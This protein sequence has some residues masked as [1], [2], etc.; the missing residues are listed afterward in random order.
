MDL[1]LSG[2]VTRLYRLLWSKN[3][4]QE[5]NFEAFTA[6]IFSQN[7]LY[8]RHCQSQGCHH[9]STAPVFKIR[10]FGTI[11]VNY[12]PPQ[13]ILILMESLANKTRKQSWFQICSVFA[14]YLTS[15][16][17]WYIVNPHRSWMMSL[18]LYFLR[19]ILTR[20]LSSW[21]E[22]F[23]G[24]LKR[25]KMLPP[26]WTLIWDV[27]SRAV[28]LYTKLC[29]FATSGRTQGKQVKWVLCIFV[30]SCF[31]HPSS[32]CDGSRSLFI[33]TGEQYHC[34]GTSCFD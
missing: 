29:R 33:L 28:Y 14:L 30:N 11:C 26:L 21:P 4:G 32:Y 18:T 17:V 24:I 9:G 13:Q 16:F 1:D 7:I 12:G 2:E 5:R 6:T 15:S 3:K 19:S 23:A 34:G 20:A 8:R 22:N 10:L 31:E 25:W 27:G